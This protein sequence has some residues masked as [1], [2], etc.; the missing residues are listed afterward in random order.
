MK[1]LIFIFFILVGSMA[2]AY[3][4][5][6]RHGYVNC[7][8]CHTTSQGGDLLTPYGRELGKEL[9]SRNDSFFAEPSAEKK[10]WE[11]KSPDWLRVGL[12]SRL[13]QTMTESS[14]ASKGRFMFM[15][16]DVDA[17][18]ELQS[19]LQIYGGVGRYEP[20]KS[21]AE[22]RDFIYVPRL[23]GRYVFTQRDGAELYSF[24]AGRFFPSYGINLAEHAYVTRRYLEFNPGQERV[25]FETAWS[26]ENYQATVTVLAQ[27]AF[28]EKFDDENGYVLQAS[29]VFGKTTRLGMN[30]YRSHLSQNGSRME[31]AFEGIF[32]LIGWNTQYSLLLQVDQI[33]QPDSKTGLVD[34]M[35]WGFEYTQGV[36][37][38]F[39]QEY[40]NA[41]TEKTD[42]HTEAYG[43]G[44]HYFPQSNFDF[45]ATFKK[46]KDSAQLSE[47]QNIVWLIAHV[48]L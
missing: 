22:W 1:S 19:G 25:S 18:A 20:T 15:Q 47:F 3:P 29:K 12:S 27:R 36:Q 28:Y 16:L 13:L 14:V 7:M 44:V 2:R 24:R 37:L 17:M 9:L 23:W 46:Q 6:I 48:Y 10:T 40:Y 11:I 43:V 32:A 41:N 34:L 33:H 45:F 4:E 31:K 30:I 5:L 39:T 38:F 8:A 42:P 35:K 21:N 26:N